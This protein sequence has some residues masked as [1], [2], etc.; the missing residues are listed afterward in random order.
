MK[1]KIKI[2]LIAIFIFLLLLILFPHIIYDKFIWKYFIGPLEADA[3]GH[4][5]KRDGVIAKEGYTIVSEIFY[6]IFLIIFIYLFYLFFEK[7]GINVDF[8]FIL[9]SL[10]FVLY[11][12]IARVIED[13]NIITPPLSYFF[14]SPLIYAQVGILFFLSLF[15]KK[16]FGI[17]LLILNLVPLFLLSFLVSFIFAISSI[18]SYYMYKKSEKD[19]NSSLF[20][21]GMPFFSTSIIILFIHVLPTHYEILIALCIALVI[22][23]IIYITKTIYSNK[24]NLSVIFSHMLDAF[25]TYFA[26]VNP[27]GFD[28]EYGE[29]HPLPDFLMKNFY[30]VGYPLLKLVV[31]M[32]IIYAIDDLKKNLKNTIKF[33]MFFLG[34]S[35]AV[36]D[37]L[38]IM[39]GI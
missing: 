22:S 26:V 37:L 19:Y 38:R 27:L 30:G 11:G 12:A 2:A 9:S 35:P 13:A 15:L 7:Y 39:L 17:L 16:R 20:F 28:I 10:P 14:I 3:V 36:R 21:L 18:L 5:V 31:V 24:I 4:P 23:F 6:G 34:L 8:K 1:F 25:T 29:K 32:G 33:F